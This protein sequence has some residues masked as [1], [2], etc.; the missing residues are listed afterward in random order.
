MAGLPPTYMPPPPPPPPP[1]F[2]GEFMK[3]PTSGKAIASLVCGIC[4]LVLV[5]CYVPVIAALVGVVLGILGIVETG[6]EGSRSGRGMA[7]AGVIISSLAI[8]ALVA[9]HVGLTM[10]QKVAEEQVNEMVTAGLD[11]DQRVILERLRTYYTENEKSLGPGGPVLT[12]GY[13]PPPANAPANDGPVDT[14]PRVTGTLTLKDLVK[15]TELSYG[16]SEGSGVGWE[17]DVTGK[18]S[19]KLVAKDWGGQVIREITISD[20]GRDIYVVTP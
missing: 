5:F 12:G 16:S 7:I 6:K 10:L 13:A 18:A 20:I 9:F 1:G 15:E 11:K 14:R 8:A 2:G 17:L 4:G 3:K 19:A